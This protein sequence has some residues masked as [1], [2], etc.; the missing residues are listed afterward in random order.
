M[1]GAL[2]LRARSIAAF[3]CGRSSLAPLSVSVKVSTNLN[4]S[5]SANR[6]ID[7]A[8]RLEAEPGTPLPYCRDADIADCFPHP[9]SL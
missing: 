7:R 3:S 2:A 6:E 5:A 1:I 4:A 8:L 9:A